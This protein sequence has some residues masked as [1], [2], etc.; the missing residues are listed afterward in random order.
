[1]DRRGQQVEVV[2][3]E[4]AFVAAAA[5]RLEALCSVEIFM[6]REACR[7]GQPGRAAA[8][9]LA[10]SHWGELL[11]SLCALP[12]SVELLAVT[13]RLE[14]GPPVHRLVALGRG[15]TAAAARRVCL[16]AFASLREALGATIGFA[17]FVPDVPGL[18][19]LLG[20]AH[21]YE[22]ARRELPIVVASP[23]DRGRAVGFAP[24]S[25]ADPSAPDRAVRHTCRWRAG[26]GDGTRLWRALGAA[27]AGTALVAH[28]HPRIAAPASARQEALR[29]LGSL[30]R[31]LQAGAGPT[32]TLATA[33]ADGERAAALALCASF[34]GASVPA[35]LYL[36]GPG[37]PSNELVGAVARHVDGS[38]AAGEREGVAGGVAVGRAVV[39]DL[40]DRLEGASAR[41]VF[42]VREAVGFVHALLPVAE[43]VPGVRVV[44]ARTAPVYAVESGGDAPLG[45]NRHGAHLQPLTLDEEARFRHTYIVGQTGTGKSTL[46][47][48]HIL[49]DIRAGRGVA[50]LDPHGS[51]VEAVLRHFPA[52]RADDLVRLDVT[53]REYPVA[54]NPLSIA[55]EDP[56]AYRLARDL[57]IDDLYAFLH[58]TYD[59]DKVG[60]PIFESHF[61]GMLGLLLGVCQPLGWAPTLMMFRSLYTNG[62]LRRRLA[63]RVTP[64]DPVTREFL[65]EAESATHDA[66]LSSVSPYITSKFTRFVS[67]FTLRAITCQRG[68]IDVDGIVRDGKVLLCDLGRGRFGDLPAGLIA[69]QLVSR[70]RGAVMGRG[71]SSDARPFC[72]YA[73]EFQIFADERIG[74]LLSEARKF[75]LAITLGHQYL[76]QLSPKIRGAVLGN[77]GTVI[78]LR[79]GANDAE[80]IAPVFAPTLGARDLLSLPNH[81]AYVRSH[82]ALGH[83]PFS[84]ELPP[85]PVG[86]RPELAH[87]L[88]EMARTRDGRPLAVAEA[89]IEH[90]YNR[91]L[92]GELLAA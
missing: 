46:M 4:G 8:S 10:R 86:G 49:H 67:D 72:L 15:A 39:S 33:R 1:M 76:D 77:V 54:F 87:A 5:V 79:I 69:S 34:E 64:H 83:R 40:L 26:E 58:Q 3:H 60:G 75:R 13:G 65:R 89:E 6:E 14:A 88:R 18:P 11:E 48:H 36:I 23:D 32:E 24:V 38:T 42:D 31:A 51:L 29:R 80:A 37:A 52:E 82:G 2:Q 56:H 9:V 28:L 84:V 74:E 73:D 62:D 41:H 71:A 61:R 17:D 53:D 27:P 50:V 30:E 44:H 20:C 57:I 7:T 70:I 59:L 16:S 78:A 90:T 22:V 81:M 47:L 21:A 92:R 55:A 45:L 43:P 19:A 25:G 35:R 91:W 66:S 85:P 12:R 63:A 68:A